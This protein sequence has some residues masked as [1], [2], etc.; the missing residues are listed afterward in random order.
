M[1]YGLRKA[2]VGIHQGATPPVAIWIPAG[3]VVRVVEGF[4]NA[5]G[6]VEIEWDGTIVQIFSVDLHDRGELIE[7]SERVKP[8][9]A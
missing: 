5:A 2:T 3:A 7:A 6:F 1:C 9:A 4:V 8:A